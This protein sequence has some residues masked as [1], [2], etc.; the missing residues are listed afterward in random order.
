MLES[1]KG[2]SMTDADG[3][4]NGSIVVLLRYLLLPGEFRHQAS[5]DGRYTNG[6]TPLHDV[7]LLLNQPQD[8]TSDPVLVYSYL[9]SK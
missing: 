9:K 4:M 7:L 6:T 2:L 1:V 3:S 5:H 8:S